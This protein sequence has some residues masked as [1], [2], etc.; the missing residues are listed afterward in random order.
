[1]FFNKLLAF[2][3][4]QRMPA[5][6]CSL[7]AF[8]ILLDTS[9]FHVVILNAISHSWLSQNGFKAVKESVGVNAAEQL[10]SK[11]QT[12]LYGFSCTVSYVHVTTW[13]TTILISLYYCVWLKLFHN[14]T[15][16]KVR[17]DQ[18]K[19]HLLFIISYAFLT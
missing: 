13:T 19:G 8:P 16:R 7:K 11:L 17:L 18:S 12:V 5:F 14:Y 6:K 1:M 9:K 10:I 3:T 15:I 4:E 2:A